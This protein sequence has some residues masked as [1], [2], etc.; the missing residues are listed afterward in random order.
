VSSAAPIVTVDDGAVSGEGGLPVLVWIHGG[1]F[2]LGA[3]DPHNVTIAGQSSGGTSALA[4]LVS[5][6]SRGLFH[7]AIAQSGS[8][9]LTQQS[10][11]P[12]RPTAR[13]SRPR[14]TTSPPET[15]A[16]SGMPGKGGVR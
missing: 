13:R 5:R 15:T 14:R 16:R 11:A 6:G 10:L 1:R 12:P 2:T 4:H 3:G 9:A 8:F 7:R